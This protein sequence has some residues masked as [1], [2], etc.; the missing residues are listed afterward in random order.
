M[1]TATFSG[2]GKYRDKLKDT[3]AYVA[4]ITPHFLKEE[5][6]VNEMRDAH[7]LKK[8]MY[9]LVDADANI[10]P[11][12]LKIPWTQWLVYCSEFE[13]KEKAEALIQN[14]SQKEQS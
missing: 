6:C 11:W 5:K 1:A 12:V 3:D 2:S 7:Q 10:P 9:A 4:L 14:L 8:K 13:F